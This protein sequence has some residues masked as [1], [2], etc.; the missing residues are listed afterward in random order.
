MTFK[1]KLKEKVLRLE[2]EHTQILHRVEALSSAVTELQYE[3][4]VNFG[5]NLKEVAKILNF[6]KRNLFGHMDKEDVFFNVISREIP[7]L[8]PVFHI[9]FAEHKEIKVN[10]E[11]LL[12]L[13]RDLEADKGT[14]RST[15]ILAKL[16]DKTNYLL[17]LLRHHVQ[18][19]DESFA[20]I[21]GAGA[22]SNNEAAKHFG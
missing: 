20:H 11:V 22:W 16:R 7:Q 10:L 1:I 4:K 8:E 15:Q 9:L 3:G 17:Y 5:R 18:V 2:K 12:F 13:V 14:S 6:F 21:L 19:E